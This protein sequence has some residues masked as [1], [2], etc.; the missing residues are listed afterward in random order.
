MN[1]RILLVQKN[2]HFLADRK[3]GIWINEKA[4]E[5]LTVLS[6]LS[7]TW[8]VLAYVFENLEMSE[9]LTAVREM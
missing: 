2:P 1:W 6:T 7:L 3:Q 8:L 9:N 4:L 5:F